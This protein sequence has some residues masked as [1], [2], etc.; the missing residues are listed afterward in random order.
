MA[1]TFGGAFEI[2]RS[3]THGFEALKVAPWPLLLGALLMQCSESTGGGNGGNFS[4]PSSQDSSYQSDFDWDSLGSQVGAALPIDLPTSGASIGAGEL[5]II[6]GMLVVGMVC[7]LACGLA[8]L[9]FRAWIHAGYL[10]L[11]EQV[12]STG[13]GDFGVL[14][15]ASDVFW[16]M[17]G[18]KVVRALISLGTTLLALA[19]GA[20][21]LIPGIAMESTALM[22]AGGVLMVL[23]IVPVMIYVSLGLKFGEHAVSL[24]GCTT[25]GALEASWELARGNR[26]RMFFY[27]LVM[28]IIAMVG[29]CMFCIGIIFTR[30]ITDT[31]VTEAYLL[32]TRPDERLEGMWS[33]GSG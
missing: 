17:A 29:I 1:R 24:D 21:L 12:L 27:L 10:R 19:P 14:F 25:M 15:G 28:G 8:L 9:A 7:V 20:L 5:A 13:V 11:H 3:L 26:L 33:L 4:A 18:Y 23:L 16:N 6:L 2:G 22:V 30:A 31:G 32:A